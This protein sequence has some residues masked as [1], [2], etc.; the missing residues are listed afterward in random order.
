MARVKTGGR[1]KGT[2]NI[3]SSELKTTL[4]VILDREF[5]HLPQLLDQLEPRDRITAIIKLSNYI[6]PKP[7]SESEKQNTLFPKGYEIVIGDNA[8]N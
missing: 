1:K 7:Q 8:P 6:L 2:K 3:L 4:K 5:E